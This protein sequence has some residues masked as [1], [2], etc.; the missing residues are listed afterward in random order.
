MLSDISRKAGEIKK[1]NEISE[2]ATVVDRLHSG[3]LTSFPSLKEM[4]SPKMGCVR[5][6]IKTGGL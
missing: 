5:F 4:R 6:A 2:I 3:D 1:N